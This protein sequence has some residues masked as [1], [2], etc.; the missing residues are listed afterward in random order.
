[1]SGPAFSFAEAAVLAERGLEAQASGDA[2]AALALYRQAAPALDAVP[3]LHN[4]LALCELALDRPEAAEAALRRALELRPLYAE[5]RNNL[6]LV[7]QKRGL[8]E[9]AAAAFRAALEIDPLYAHA[10]FNLGNVEL[11]AGRAAAAAALFERA[12]AL[13]GG[14]FPKA[15]MNLGIAL[16]EAGDPPAAVRA[17]ERARSLAPDDAESAANLA[18][19]RLMTGDWE[20]GWAEY[21][22]RWLLPGYAPPAFP[23]PAWHG[24]DLAGKRL[25]LWTEQGAGTSIQFLRYA[26]VLAGRGAR[27]TVACEEPLR[28]LAA[29]AEGVAAVV[30]RGEAVP[31]GAFDFHLPLV[32]AARL[33]GT[34]LES[35]PPPARF[36]GVARSAP[37][38]PPFRVAL[39]WTGNPA[40]SQNAR[41]GVPLEKFAALARAAGERFSWRAFQQGGASLEAWPAGAPP[42]E[43]PPH[44]ADFYETAQALAEADLVVTSDTALAHLAG[45]LG[46]PTALLLM[47]APDW[48]WQQGGEGD[49]YDERTPWY[50]SVRL[51]RQRLP[52]AWDAPLA[53]LA[54]RLRE[55]SG[56]PL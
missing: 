41:R 12:L 46:V 18:L 34:R 15:A 51:F 5:A 53:A 28:R 40:F 42:L 48:R 43:P 49:P 8:A 30:P 52:G 25:L 10:A 4:N 29:A 26:A 9:E 3:E 22:A 1:M 31:P 33:C 45:S 16:L 32:S 2:A 39:A 13:S 56:G 14:T 21:E 37:G 44:F 35:V 7:L 19:A 47:A 20:R 24:E 6:G 17:H 27:V 55:W 54:A 36:R 50:P 23:M 11:E 38:R